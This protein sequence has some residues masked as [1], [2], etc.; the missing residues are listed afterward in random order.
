[1]LDWDP[2][3]NDNVENITFEKKT[4]RKLGAGRC[5]DDRKMRWRMTADVNALIYACSADVA[6]I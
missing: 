3:V 1:M 2:V 6:A 4:S 5:D